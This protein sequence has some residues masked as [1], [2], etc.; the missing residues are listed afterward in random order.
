MASGQENFEVL[1]GS[2][3]PAAPAPTPTPGQGNFELLFGSGKATPPTGTY[4]QELAAQRPLTPAPH[5]DVGTDPDALGAPPRSGYK[6]AGTMALQTGGAA[7]GA[8]LGA[9]T[10]PFAPVAVPVFSAAG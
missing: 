6:E 4:A 8:T 7:A 5:V 3:P 10:G 1:F 2:S 9:M